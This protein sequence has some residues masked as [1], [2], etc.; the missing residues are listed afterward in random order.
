[1]KAEVP[2]KWVYVRLGSTNCK[3]CE[4]LLAELQRLLGGSTYDQ[5]PLPM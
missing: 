2:K 3:V 5:I 1:M 4:E